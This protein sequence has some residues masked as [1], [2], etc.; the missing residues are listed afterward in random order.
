MIGEPFGPRY[1]IIRLLG[2]GGMGAVYQAWDE[3]LGV[4]VAIKVIRPEVMED[5]AAAAEIERRLEQFRWRYT[6]VS[7]F[8]PMSSAA[9]TPINTSAAAPNSNA[10]DPESPPVFGSVLGA[11]VGVAVPAVVAAVAAA[12]APVVVAA[13]VAAAVAAVVVAAV[14]AAAVAAVV[15]AAVVAAAVAAVVV[16]A[17]VPTAV[18][19]VCSSGAAPLV[20]PTKGTSNTLNTMIV[21]IA[22]TTA[23]DVLRIGILLITP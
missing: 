2:I 10:L 15:V 19:V 7:R 23:R 9:A 3:E 4:A 5:P 20:A 12:V 13:V 1:H 16:A 17:S 14:V 22:T 8:R 6:V 11:L 21:A 18:A